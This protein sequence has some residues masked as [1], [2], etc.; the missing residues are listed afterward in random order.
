V[1]ADTPAAVAMVRLELTHGSHPQL[2]ALARQ[3][4]TAQNREIA[5][6][7]SWLHTWYHT[8]A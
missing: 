6:M 3:I 2:K 8:P 1:A 7:T 5:Q 4:I